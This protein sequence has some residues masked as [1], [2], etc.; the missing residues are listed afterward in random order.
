MR[1]FLIA[2]VMALGVADPGASAPP[3]YP[4][5]V[6][7]QGEYVGFWSDTPGWEVYEYRA[8]GEGF[9]TIYSAPYQT[10]MGSYQVAVTFGSLNEF[11]IVTSAPIQAGKEGAIDFDQSGGFDWHD[12][13]AHT[14]E[15]PQEHQLTYWYGNT[16]S[17]GMVQKLIAVMKHD[18]AATVSFAG[19]KFPISLRGFAASYTDMKRCENHRV[20]RVLED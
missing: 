16:M 17:S 14:I 7:S 15:K 19:S 12:V 4:T 11:A 18:K 1:V 6:M 3:I 2:A 5:D 9:C 10:P 20:G 8:K 13:V